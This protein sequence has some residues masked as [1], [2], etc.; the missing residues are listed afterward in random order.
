MKH[1]TSGGAETEM[2][3]SLCTDLA[4]GS[5]ISSLT[6]MSQAY[7]RRLAAATIE[8]YIL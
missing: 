6:R 7:N 2:L 8:L 3:S 4:P 1:R 5:A